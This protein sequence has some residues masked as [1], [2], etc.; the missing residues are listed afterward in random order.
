MKNEPKTKK[1]FG[2]CLNQFIFLTTD[3][4]NPQIIQNDNFFQG[5]SF[6]LSCLIPFYSP[7]QQPFIV[8]FA[9]I[10]ITLD[11][12]WMTALCS[13]ILAT[14]QSLLFCLPFSIPVSKHTVM[15]DSGCGFTV[16]KGMRISLQCQA[17]GSPPINY[18]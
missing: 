18:V 15:S 12:T 4:K 1:L 10:F 16:P 5:N 2:L 13:H 3:S 6:H 14:S 11:S 9:E 17:W 8:P 7:H